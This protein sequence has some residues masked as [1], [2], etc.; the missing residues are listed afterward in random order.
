MALRREATQIEALEGVAHDHNTGWLR[1]TAISNLS[2]RA[3]REEDERA[4]RA[5]C[6]L[7]VL[8]EAAV[9][10][11]PMA[12][13]LWDV[14]AGTA[15]MLLERLQKCALLQS[16]PELQPAG[17]SRA[18]RMHD[19][20][21]NLARR[22]LEAPVIPASQEALPG[23]GLSLPVAHAQLLARYRRQATDGRW[24]S[25]PDD[26]HLYTY[27][28]WHL[29]QAGAADEIDA[30]LREETADGQLGWYQT[31]DRRVRPRATCRTW[32]G[33]GD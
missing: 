33:P 31:R 11:A 27:L 25:V 19:L 24:H 7:A 5:F 22:L 29:E 3:L 13:T 8:P 28:I 32:R 9:L 12:A 23:L 2:V 15:D 4:W 26:G 21:H 10:G 17:L 16:G 20:L 18:Y 14:E 6:W 30:L 1:F